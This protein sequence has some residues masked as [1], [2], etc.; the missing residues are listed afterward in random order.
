MLYSR[1]LM[2]SRMWNA[3]HFVRADEIHV[4][5]S[6]SASMETAQ[7]KKSCL[8]WQTN[9]AQHRSCIIT[10]S[11]ELEFCSLNQCHNELY[12]N[13]YKYMWEEIETKT[14]W[15]DKTKNSWIIS[16]WLILFSATAMQFIALLNNFCLIKESRQIVDFFFQL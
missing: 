7:C 2:S 10:G 3:W 8:V 9:R 6:K 11:K 1:I 4:I 12:L 16:A 14:F 15:N 5:L 13:K